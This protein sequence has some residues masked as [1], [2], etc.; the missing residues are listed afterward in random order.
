[1]LPADEELP[2]SSEQT[3]RLCLCLLLSI[4]LPV[5]HGLQ[6]QIYLA[7]EGTEIIKEISLPMKKQLFAWLWTWLPLICDSDQ[8]V[9]ITL[10]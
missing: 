2:L 7:L 10:T 6:N 8:Q 9:L 4:M 3:L 1:M 5:T